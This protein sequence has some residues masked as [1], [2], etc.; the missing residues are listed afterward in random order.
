MVHL[1][2]PL[3]S[4]LPDDHDAPAPAQAAQQ[5]TALAVQGPQIPPYGQRKGW[6]PKS[7]ADFGDGGAYPE[8]PVAQY[9]L[10]LGR[11]K[12]SAGNTLALQVD[13]DGNVNYG[14]IATQGQRS[15]VH[16]QTSFKDLV[17]LAQ[18]TDV[19]KDVMAMERPSEDE[20]QATADRTKA[21]LERLVQGKIK[22]AQPKNVQQTGGDV[23]Y[24]R[25]TPQN[26]GVEKQKIIKMMEVVEDPLE[27]PRFKG[28][29]VPRGPPSPPP[30]VLRSPPRKVTAQEQKEWMIPPCVSNWKNNKGYT[31]PLDKRLAADGRGLQDVHINDRFAQFSEALYV[32][33]RHAREEVRQRALMQQKIAQKEKDAKEENLR[34]LAQRAREER[35]GVVVQPSAAR[36]GAA[37]GG[38]VG[39]AIAGYGSDDDS[40]D[41]EAVAIARGQQG[42]AAGAGR[43]TPTP[44]GRRAGDYSSDEEGAGASAGADGETEEERAAARER[45][46]MRRE[47]RK[48]RE[49]E[50]RMSNMGTEQ[51]AKML[52]KAT[53]RDISEKIALGLAKP[54]MSKDSMLDARL[55]NREQYS[56][57]FG[58]ADAYNLYDKPLFSGSSAAAAIYKP[59]GRD[60]DDE[61]YEVGGEEV[62]KAMRNDRFGLGVA[63]KGRG[64]EGADTSEIREGP[65]AFERDTADPFGVDAFLESAKA[66]SGAGEKK[67]GLDTGDDERRKRQ[68]DD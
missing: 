13:A 35:S 56:D 36:T 63:G 62:E 48:E 25:Y 31:I 9:P 44:E 16:V 6:K 42:Q 17:P 37:M 43:D 60:V 2:A 54:T 41:E 22:A 64:F 4:T 15:G 52:A 5:S 27:P 50:M 66:G 28:K 8:C 19:A 40:E 68:R 1:P 21:A 26:G 34:L 67:R 24:M 55:F 23:S 12:T 57:S 61:G 11:K 53:G 10:E 65:V 45:D 18:R 39:A 59:R 29:K 38:S 20:V 14:A 47:R 49:R 32:A 46:E 3:H 51:R 7:Q 30:P 58:S 33:D